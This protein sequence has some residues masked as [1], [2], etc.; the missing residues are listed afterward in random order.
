MNV[1]TQQLVVAIRNVII[2]FRDYQTH[3]TSKV[4]A[5]ESMITAGSYQCICKTGFKT[6]PTNPKGCVDIDECN[7]GIHNCHRDIRDTISKCINTPG[8]Y[9][10][11]CLDGYQGNGKI[12]KKVDACLGMVQK[13]MK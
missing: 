5:S 12:C 8:T 9:T 6:D 1:L 13:S 11:E 2:Q 7:G 4:F 10:C 3:L